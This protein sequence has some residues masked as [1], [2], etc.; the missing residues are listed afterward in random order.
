M[1]LTIV[2]GP[3]VDGIRKCT[4]FELAGDDSYPGGGWPLTVA[5]LGFALS[6][7]YVQVSPSAGYVL[8]YDHANGSVLA[9]EQTDPADAGGANVPLVEVADETDLTAIVAARGIAWGR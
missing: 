2:T 5:Q 4:V 7:D 3:D 9:F 6:V 1:E 8:E